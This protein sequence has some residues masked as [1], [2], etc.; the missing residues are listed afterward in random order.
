MPV[1][2]NETAD[3]VLQYLYSTN[4]SMR[5]AIEEYCERIYGRQ[6]GVNS[7][8]SMSQLVIDDLIEKTGTSFNITPAGQEIML[9]YGSYSAYK[10]TIEEKMAAKA[11][12]APEQLRAFS[13]NT[14]GRKT[15][16]FWVIVLLAA[17]VIGIVITAI[18]H[19]G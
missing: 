9:K 5:S 3:Q 2:T 12:L 13:K 8:S 10:K 7:L 18:R 16:A 11:E 14:V 17:A 1:S 15:I 4:S 6:S 19:K